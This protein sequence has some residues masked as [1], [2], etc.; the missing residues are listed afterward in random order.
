M[1]F[2]SIPTPCHEKWNE[3]SP[4]E[5]GAFCNVCSK[6]VID[7]T[8]LS[9]EEV[10]NYFL[11]NRGKK[12]CGRF[13]NDQLTDADDLLPYL[14]AGSIP[15]WKKFLAIV[16]IVFGS[17]LSGCSDSTIGKIKID[18]IK[19][20]EKIL[21]TTGVML[22]DIKQEE[23]VEERIEVC[24]TTVGIMEISMGEI[25]PLP[26]EE[27]V[28]GKIVIEMPGQSVIDS[29]NRKILDENGNQKKENEQ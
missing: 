2:I 5:Q 3:M 28:I 17:F 14:L 11:N 29:T 24:T 12:N 18:G 22:V 27:E 7:F 16:L 6:T 8:S 15:F 26:F 23:Q 20:K 4:D 13:R 21:M 1:L 19:S 25:A 10:Q 9:D